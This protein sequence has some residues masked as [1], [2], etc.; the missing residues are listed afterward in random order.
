MS[1]IRFVEGFYRITWWRTL[2]ETAAPRFWWTLGALI[3]VT[4]VGSLA[5]QTIVVFVSLIAAL[6][7]VA[8]WLAVTTSEYF[9]HR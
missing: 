9:K 8:A 2:R 6:L 5:S 3:V 1:P 4:A 7:L